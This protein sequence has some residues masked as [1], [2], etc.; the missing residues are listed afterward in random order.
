VQGELKKSYSKLRQ[1]DGQYLAYSLLDQAV[2]MLGPIVKEIGKAV[3]DEKQA[4]RERSYKDMGHIHR[5][6]DELKNMS[7]KLKPFKNLLMHVIEDKAI[8]PGP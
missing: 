7:R 8:S 3:D 5:L 1:Y 4:L 2:D 6:R